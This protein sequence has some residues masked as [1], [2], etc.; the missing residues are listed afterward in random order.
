MAIKIGELRDKSTD[1]LK[2]QL[3]ELQEEMFN[4][5]S[6]RSIGQIERPH[7]YSEVRKSIARIKTILN[8]RE[9]E[10]RS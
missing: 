6:R 8:Q 1:E 5:R 10:A 4:L 2:Q 9:R 3:R 7:H